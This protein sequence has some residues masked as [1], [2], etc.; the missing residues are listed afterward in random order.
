V[1]KYDAIYYSLLREH[2]SLKLFKLMLRQGMIFLD[3]GTGVES[4]SIVAPEVIGDAGLL[5]RP[6]DSLDLADKVVTLLNEE[7]REELSRKSGE[8]VKFFTAKRMVQQYLQAYHF[9]CKD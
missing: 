9:L 1:S 4:Y 7:I 3:V 6:H 2:Y 5:Y 8:R